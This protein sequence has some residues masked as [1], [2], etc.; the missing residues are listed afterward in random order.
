MLTHGYWHPSQ[1]IFF[2]KLRKTCM[3]TR[4]IIQKLYFSNSSP[5]LPG[6]KALTICMPSPIYITGHI[7]IINLL[8]TPQRRTKYYSVKYDLFIFKS[9]LFIDSAV[10][11]LGY[12]LTDQ[13]KFYLF[14]TLRRT[15]WPPFCR[16]HSQTPFR[17]RKL[18]R[19]DSNI[20]EV[21]CWGSIRLHWGIVLLPITMTQFTESLRI[22]TLRP[23][24]TYVSTGLNVLIRNDSVTPNDSRYDG[25]HWF[26]HVMAYRLLYSKPLLNTNEHSL[27]IGS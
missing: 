16:R 27:P 18:L 21:C 24:D 11:D 23:V 17:G 3:L 1:C 9:D 19:F 12:V 13:T 14:D 26:I 10:S 22:N 5:R 7:L 8:Q 6:V 25:Q 4:I 2:Q 20:T 15:K